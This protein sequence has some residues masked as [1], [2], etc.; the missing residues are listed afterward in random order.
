MERSL[1]W[2]E[3]DTTGWACSNCRWR[4]LVPTLLAGDEAM[5]AYDR[6]AAAKFPEHKCEAETR[7][8]VAKQETKRASDASFAS[9]ARMLIMR[10]FKPKDAVDLV[11]REIAMEAGNDSKVTEKARAHAE[12]FLMRIRKG[13]I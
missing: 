12:E 8:P 7:P 5:A 13:L 9:R 6:L 1:I 3:G 10:G 11:L 2:I 4:F